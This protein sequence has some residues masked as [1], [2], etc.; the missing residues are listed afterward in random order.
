[1]LTL[2]YALLDNQVEMSQVVGG[3]ITLTFDIIS[4]IILLIKAIKSSNITWKDFFGMLGRTLSRVFK[5]NKEV[6]DGSS[7]QRDDKSNS[8]NI[9][10]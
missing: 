1:M 8:D 5:K 4:C 2:L 3:W 6:Q 10:K 9:R 7:L